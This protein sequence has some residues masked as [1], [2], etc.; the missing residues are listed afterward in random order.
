MATCRSVDVFVIGDWWT[1]VSM[2][3]GSSTTTAWR[4]VGDNCV[5]SPDGKSDNEDGDGFYIR[6][7]IVIIPKNAVVPKNTVI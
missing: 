6:D 7:G 2:A 3:T 4:I 5:I 1:I